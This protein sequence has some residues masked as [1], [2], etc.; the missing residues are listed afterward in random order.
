MVCPFCG[1]ERLKTTNS[2]KS[3]RNNQV[4]RRRQCDSCGR[5]F[6]TRE[7]IDLSDM[8]V[9]KSSGVIEPYSRS[10]LLSSLL[11]SCDHRLDQADDVFALADTVEKE[12]IGNEEVKTSGIVAACSEILSHFDKVASVKYSSYY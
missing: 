11:R 7:Y 12:I 8:A 6:S 10:K 3:K 9:I 4:W 1:N 2:R 5:L